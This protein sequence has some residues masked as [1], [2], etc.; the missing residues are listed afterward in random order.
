MIFTFHARGAPRKPELSK[1]EEQ[2]CEWTHSVFLITVTTY[3]GSLKLISSKQKPL[4]TYCFKFLERQRAF[5]TTFSYHC[6]HFLCQPLLPF[7]IKQKLSHGL[8][9]TS[10]C[11]PITCHIILSRN[12]SSISLLFTRLSIPLTYF[13]FFPLKLSE[14]PTS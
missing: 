11:S 9:L 5:L 3:E 14:N 13:L 6:F 10:I 12:H 2:V 8:F 4:G 7:L 1:Q